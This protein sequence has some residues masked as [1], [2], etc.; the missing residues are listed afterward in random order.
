MIREEEIENA[1]KRNDAAIDD[2]ILRFGLQQ[3]V[4]RDWWWSK[5]S[6]QGNGGEASTVREMYHLIQH[7]VVTI[8]EEILTLTLTLTL[9]LMGG[10][11]Y[12]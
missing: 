10:C 12:H 2:L 1:E 5:I 8:T 7:E 4:R 9:T 6:R 3:D 11:H